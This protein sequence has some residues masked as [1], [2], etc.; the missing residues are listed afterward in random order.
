MSQQGQYGT[1]HH[2]TA[3][4][5]VMVLC[6]VIGAS[7][8]ASAQSVAIQGGT[9]T[10]MDS[11]GGELQYRWKGVGGFF[12]VGYQERL[13]FGAYA[14]YRYRGVDYGLGDRAQDFSLSTDNRGASRF[15]YVRGLYVERKGER[16][17]ITAFAGMT[18]N[19]FGSMFYDASRRLDT[20]GAGLF[21]HENGKSTFY[22]ANIAQDRVTSLQSAGYKITSRITLGA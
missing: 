21:K 11:S 18:T 9:S 15:F 20:T 14:G 3:I 2:S 4:I 1:M 10:L 13:D 7:I 12:S 5:A 17:S 8:V 19:R 22:S 6:V 16:D